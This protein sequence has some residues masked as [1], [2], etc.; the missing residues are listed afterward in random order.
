[1]LDFCVFV[2]YYVN[3]T[4]V[5]NGYTSIPLKISVNVSD[6]FTVHYFR[7]GKNFKFA[8]ESHNFWELT[9]VDSGNAKIVAGNVTHSLKQGQGFLHR[10]NE[11]HNI[12]TDDS[13]ANSTVVSFACKNHAVKILAG[14]I[15]NFDDYEKS[16]LN[17]IL[18]ET[19]ISFSDKLNDIYLKKMHEKLNA[20]F[21]HKQIL[22]N[23]IEL[24]LVSL[25]RNQ[26][27]LSNHKINDVVH[28]N[29]NQIVENVKSILNSKLES[30]ELVNLDKISFS[31]GY[32]KSYLKTS[33]KK[34]TGYSIIQYFIK[35]K[36]DKA[37]K[38]LSQQKYSISEIADVLGYASIHYFSRQ[39]K[40]ST[41]MSPSEY[42]NSIKP[43]N[44]L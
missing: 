40:N 37:K 7:Y 26:Q 27:S 22:K 10:P 24:L 20:P 43:D 35:L 17:K 25:I 15:L 2:L 11:W 12:Y 42:V 6:V 38:L 32:S 28:V 30:V 5:I 14:K 21:A 41:G 39:F 31:L 3:M 44:L 36:M 4:K 19:Q 18:Q 23:S 29:T 8:G 34:S 1:M 33:F 16:L 13:F 9:Y